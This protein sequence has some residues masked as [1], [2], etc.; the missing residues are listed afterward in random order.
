MVGMVAVIG[1]IV[2]AALGSRVSALAP[3]CCYQVTGSCR[4]SC[5]EMSLVEISTDEEKREDYLTNLNRLCS[6]LLVGFWKC[7]NETLEEVDRGADWVGRPCCSVPQTAGCRLACLKAQSRSE[8][9]GTCRR[10]D[11]ISFYFCV[12]RQEVGESCCQQSKRSE[13]RKAC[14]EVFRSAMTP[15]KTIREAVFNQCAQH[16]PQ[17][18]RCLR[19]YTHTTPADNPTRNLHCCDQS[20]NRQCREICRNVLRTQTTDQEIIDSL[21]KGGCGPPLPH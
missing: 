14:W 6:K 9:S 15:S 16:S 20:S 7:M 3:T 10:S 1:V 8:I 2:L 13:C 4:R 17:V 19:N 21:I 11:E 12:E 18:L 5:E